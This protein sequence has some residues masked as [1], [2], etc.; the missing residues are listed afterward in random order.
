VKDSEY[1]STPAELTVLTEW[2]DNGGGVLAMGDHNF[3]GSAMCWNIPRVGT[4]RAWL[5]DDNDGRSVPNRTGTDRHDTNRPQNASQDASQ[6][7]NP[8]MIPNSVERDAIAQ[9]LEWKKYSV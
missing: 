2:M 5:K 3:L 7:P 9:P 1:S 4:M 8:A 6:T